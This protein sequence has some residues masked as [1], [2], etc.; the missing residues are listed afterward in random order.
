[1]NK[2]ESPV[3]L[4]ALDPGKSD[5]GFWVRFH[6][7]VMVSA[8][9]ELARRRMAIEP[10]IAEVV[11]GWRRALVP[12]TLL[13]AALAG[14]LLVGQE[15]AIIPLPPLALEDALMQ[16]LPVDPI[17]TVLGRDMDLDEMAFLNAVERF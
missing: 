15:E 4:E 11:F 3:P 8:R 17:P 13:A 9:E 5:S 12:M 14:I 6:S 16:D 7:R 10:T 2:L 1:M